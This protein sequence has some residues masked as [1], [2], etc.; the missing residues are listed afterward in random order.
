LS[1]ARNLGGEDLVQISSIGQV[2]ASTFM[3]ARIKWYDFS[4]YGLL[5]SL[6]SRS[7]QARG[8]SCKLSC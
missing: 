2:K 6:T 8:G 3:G 5:W 1:H 7:F 4:L